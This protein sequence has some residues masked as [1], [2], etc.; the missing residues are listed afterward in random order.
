MASTFFD[1]LF[2]IKKA[3]E[4]SS[5]FLLTKTLHHHVFYATFLP[6][7]KIEPADT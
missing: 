2:N 3:A 7:K 6:I 1:N 4:F 5:F